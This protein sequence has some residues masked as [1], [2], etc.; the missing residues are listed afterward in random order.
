[1]HSLYKDINKQWQA[2]VDPTFHICVHLPQDLSIKIAAV[3]LPARQT[4]QT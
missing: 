4:I 1:M 3:S 2:T